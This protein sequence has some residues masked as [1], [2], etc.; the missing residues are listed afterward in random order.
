MPAKDINASPVLPDYSEIGRK[1]PKGVPRVVDTNG[2]LESIELGF[3]TA[4]YQGEALRHMVSDAN[5]VAVALLLSD[6]LPITV[7]KLKEFHVSPF[8]FAYAHRMIGTITTKN[9]VYSFCAGNKFS[10]LVATD[11]EKQ[12]IELENSRRL[13]TSII[14]TNKVFKIAENWLASVPV[15]IG[16]LNR[17]CDIHISVSPHW[18]GL[19][20]LGDIPRGQFVP[21]YF[22]WWTYK[23]NAIGDNNGPLAVEFSEPAKRLLQLFISDPKYNLR[24]EIIFT[25]LP[26]L[27]PGNGVVRTNYPVAPVFFN[28]KGSAV[29][30]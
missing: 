25:N 14:N 30:K 15:D 16:A 26:D 27:F 13:R 4:A 12:C 23:T 22:V 10:E 29:G 5:S 2:N 7:E 8:G 11:Y 1:L 3:T 9:Y 21:I 24:P 6:D 19:P 20:K 17:D 18:N 28:I